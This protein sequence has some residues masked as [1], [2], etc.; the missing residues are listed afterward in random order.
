MFT[1]G[2]RVFNHR[3]GFGTVK[4]RCGYLVYVKYD[5]GGYNNESTHY[6]KV[7]RST[8]PSA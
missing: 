5:R 1:I 2:T 4:G 7:V 3:F 8:V 6:L